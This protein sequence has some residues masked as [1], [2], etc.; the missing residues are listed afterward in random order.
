LSEIGSVVIAGTIIHWRF[1]MIR[2]VASIYVI[3]LKVAVFIALGAGL[4]I[5]TIESERVRAKETLKWG[6][7]RIP[8]IRR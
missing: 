5:G 2:Q 3:L 7:V 4:T 6:L 1:S 8:E